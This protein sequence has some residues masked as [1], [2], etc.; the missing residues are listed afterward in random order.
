MFSLRKTGSW[1]SFFN[2]LNRYH[3]ADLTFWRIYKM[4]KTVTYIQQFTT[5]F[6]VTLLHSE[7]TN[8]VKSEFRNEGVL[9]YVWKSICMSRSIRSKLT[10]SCKVVQS[11][12]SWSCAGL[13]PGSFSQGLS[14][15]TKGVSI[16]IE[17]VQNYLFRRFICRYISLSSWANLL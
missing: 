10:I 3:L 17:D 15:R 14:S 2:P 12:H 13:W 11:I 16:D 1:N 5:P 9:R 7:Y 6:R 4:Y 8:S